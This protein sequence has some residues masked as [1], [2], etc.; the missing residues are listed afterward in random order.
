LHSCRRAAQLRP[1]SLSTGRLDHVGG[2]RSCRDGCTSSANYRPSS[3]ARGDDCPGSGTNC[4]YDS[5]R[6]HTG[7]SAQTAGGGTLTP[8]W[9][10]SLTSVNPFQAVNPWQAQYFAT[11][12]SQ[13]LLARQ[14]R[15]GWTPSWQPSRSR[16]TPPRIPSSWTPERAGTTGKPATTSDIEWAYTMALNK[17]TKSNRVSRLSLIKGAADYTAGTPTLWPAS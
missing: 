1:A 16:R 10:A 4:G 9:G 6:Q 5:A 3:R 12:F 8:A 14:T 7:G 15:R 2:T 17:A 13:L 11:V